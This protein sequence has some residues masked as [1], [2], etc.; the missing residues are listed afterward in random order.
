MTQ[1]IS[2]LAGMFVFSALIV[3]FLNSGFRK[4]SVG[5]FLFVILFSLSCVYANSFS[6]SGLILG[7]GI[8]P[9]ENVF[10]FNRSKTLEVNGNSIL[11]QGFSSFRDYRILQVKEDEE[12]KLPMEM[13]DLSL[14]GKEHQNQIP[15]K[16]EVDGI[17]FA[18]SGGGSAEKRIP[19]PSPMAMFDGLDSTFWFHDNHTMGWVSLDLGEEYPSIIDSVKIK[20][21]NPGWNDIGI[22]NF[23]FEGSDDNVQWEILYTDRF[24]NEVDGA[25]WQEFKI[26][27]KKPF[28]F[29]RLRIID[30]YASH[31]GI[32]EIELYEIQLGNQKR[33][34]PQFLSEVS[35]LNEALRLDPNDLKTHID[36]ARVYKK[37]GRLQL[38]IYEFKDALRIDDKNFEARYGLVTVYKEML[39]SDPNN[40]QAH[41]DLGLTYKA[42]NRLQEAVEE[43][44][45]VL[46][47]KP[48]F[49]QAHLD[50]GLIYKMFERPQEAVGEFKE[51]LRIDPNNV[52][53]H[54]NIGLIYAP[55]G[56]V[57][58]FIPPDHPK[59]FEIWQKAEVAFREV[60]RIEPNNVSAMVSLGLLDIE[61]GRLQE[62]I[63]KFEQAL[64]INYK[65]YQAHYNLGTIYTQLGQWQKAI[66]HLTIF[67]QPGLEEWFFGGHRFNSAILHFTLAQVYAET[68]LGQKALSEY[69][70]AVSRNPGFGH[71]NPKDFKSKIVSLLKQVLSADPQNLQAYIDLGWIYSHMGQIEKAA[72]E[73]REALRIDDKN[74][75]AR[76]EFIA[77]NK[78]LLRLDP[79]NL[80]A[81]LDLG[82]LYKKND[83]LQDAVVEFKEVLRI[84]PDSAQTHFDLA[85]TYK[86]LGLLQEAAVEFKEALRIDPN[87]AQTR[88][89]LAQTY[90]ELD[91]LQEAAVEFREVLRIEPD[92]L[93][94]LLNQGLLKIEFGNLEAA[95]VNFV[96][97]IHLDSNNLQAHYNLGTLYAQLGLWQKTIDEYAMLLQ[98]DLESSFFGSDHLNSALM[99]YTLAEAYIQ[100]GLWRKALIEYKTAINKDPTLALHVPKSFQARVFGLLLV[101]VLLS[102]CLAVYCREKSSSPPAHSSYRPDIDGLRAIAVLSV[103]I[104]HAIPQSAPGG[105]IGVDIFFVISGYLISGI[106]FKGIDS[107]SFSFWDF[108][109]KRIK[110]IFPALIIVLITVW[111]IGWFALIINDYKMLGKHITAGAAFFL[112]FTVWKEAGYFDTASDLKPLLHLWSLGVEEQ[113][114]LLWP[115]VLYLAWRWKSGPLALLCLLA[116]TSFALNVWQIRTDAISAFFLPHT[117]MWELMMG[118]LL[119]WHELY[120]GDQQRALL[121]RRL[122]SRFQPNTWV[123]FRNALAWIGLGMIIFSVMGLDKAHP[124]PGWRALLPVFGSFLLIAA[125]RFAWLNRNILASRGLVFIGLIS[126][127]LYLWHWPLLSYARIALAGEPASFIKIDAIA[128]AFILS[129]LT[130]RFVEK[131]IR[132]G[133]FR[134]VKIMVPALA[135]VVIFL[136]LIGFITYKSNGFAWRFPKYLQQV[137]EA[138]RDFT[139]SFSEA[140][141]ENGMGPNC[142]ADTDKGDMQEIP[143]VTVWGDCAA[144]QLYA[145]F[146]PLQK[147]LNFQFDR[148][149]FNFC[150]PFAGTGPKGFFTANCVEHNA[151]VLKK[152]EARKHHTV[153]LAGFWLS[154]PEPEKMIAGVLGLLKESGVKEIILFGPLPIWKISLQSIALDYM[155]SHS[156][157]QIPER[158][159]PSLGHSKSSQILDKKLRSIA[160]QFGAIYISPYEILCNDEG[161]LARIGDELTTIDAIHLAPVAAQFLANKVFKES[162]H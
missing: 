149:G 140:S 97:A 24:D 136:G 11:K 130:Y 124:Y 135:S 143:L 60:L 118:G 98:G 75:E 38:A 145:G 107:G 23:A 105:F 5:G 66:D 103:V 157:D 119:A 126:Y 8:V 74:I 41:Y 62:A 45:E 159:T 108:Y 6:G 155:I 104:F 80:Q 102:S 144:E 30:S 21:V 76:D 120:K 73:F 137:A 113:Y 111:S 147:S 133:E 114:Y 59:E 42:F 83:R 92:H 78:K 123:L 112:N 79:N 89:N 96:K 44:K 125:G 116:T 70:T 4:Y 31:V 91:R 43:L 47:I 33:V 128:L 154:Y 141:C 81:H 10:L 122:T 153:M 150:P 139:S 82:W 93:Q 48:T 49:I 9:F 151:R 28:R 131:P 67:L 152:I 34:E 50:L 71:Q 37:Y 2:I 161:C 35:T 88:Y 29:Y 26:P 63:A 115:P 17:R 61:F 85:Q 90:K 14:T 68:G 129:W 57:G 110:R 12:D 148:S 95:V 94:A 156:T 56:G 3:A 117:R 13:D 86:K 101:L 134:K 127:P 162:L 1:D 65:D 39:H 100:T 132:F 87:N 54:M 158:M 32:G 16:L 7:T 53:A 146:E 22:K 55:K 69:R 20:S 15:T 58:L 52:P 142:V 36:L 27:H 46:R 40:V 109:G 106:L 18:V 99:H 19:S 72:V 160:D 121:S 84:D 25:V 51:V 64:R 138:Q 77:I